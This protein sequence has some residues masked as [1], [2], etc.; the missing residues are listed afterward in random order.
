MN[1]SAYDQISELGSVFIDLKRNLGRGATAEVYAAKLNGNEYAA[2]IYHQDTRV[3]TAK[4]RAMLSNPPDSMYMKV[5]TSK[6]AQFT[7]PIAMLRDGSGYD[8]GF[9]M[10][11]VDL[12][13]SFPLDYFYD[14]T[15]SKKLNSRSEGA[16]SY[17]LEIARNVSVLVSDLH[18]HGHK[19]IDLK[20]Q[21]IR[22]QRSSHVVSFLDCDGFSISGKNGQHYPAELVSTDYIAPEAF[23]YNTSPRKLGEE[24]D[25]YALAVILFQLLTRGTHP[26]QGMVLDKSINA[27]TNDE[28]AS[29]GLYPHGMQLDP[30]I[31]PR[32]QSIH[33]LFDDKLWAL[34]DKAFTGSP[35]YRPTAIQW[36][37]CFNNLLAGDRIARCEKEP[38]DVLH[39]RF[40]GKQCP[41]CYLAG[42]TSTRP[43]PTKV[44]K[45]ESLLLNPRS[46]SIPPKS[47]SRQHYTSIRNTRK[48][49][50][51]IP[52]IV[53]IAVVVAIILF[54]LIVSNLSSQKSDKDA[55]STSDVS[56]S[57][58]SETAISDDD[59]IA[60]FNNEKNFQR[61]I[62][63]LWPLIESRRLEIIGSSMQT[64]T[65]DKI[66]LDSDIARRLEANEQW[67]YDTKTGMYIVIHN[68]TM[69]KIEGVQIDLYNKNTC[70][71]GAGVILY[72]YHLIFGKPLLTN[73]VKA[74]KFPDSFDYNAWAQQSDGKCILIS[75]AW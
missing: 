51:N 12:G 19:F 41:T 68:A 20:P 54:F 38:S 10:P 71:R 6:F 44:V 72:S 7:W 57:S 11:L 47:V 26:F 39:M 43:L 37:E 60:I 35:S 5:G 32:P 23:K 46:S 29:L 48:S 73:D 17:K 8:V 30:R 42:L 3:N 9:L 24:Q 16:L 28:K 36:V 50:D 15:L 53:F 25:L 2:K 59:I 55:A 74:I 61:R 75:K 34:F 64:P 49:S 67:M 1:Y 40:T 65:D 56:V 63:K 27:N 45:P 33:F 13:N 52:L 14:Q 4:I 70:N 18:R 22:V 69:D 58:K 31:T 66:F 21:N 62:D